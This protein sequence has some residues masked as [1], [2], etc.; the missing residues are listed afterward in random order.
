[1][2]YMKATEMQQDKNILYL[3]QKIFS[4]MIDKYY[5]VVYDLQLLYNSTNFLVIRL[6]R[7]DT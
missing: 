6:E 3:I 5:I 4:T 2:K 7:I 1:M